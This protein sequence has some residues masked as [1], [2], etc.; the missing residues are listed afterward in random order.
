MGP[1]ERVIDALR[2]HGCRPRVRGDSVRAF[3]PA[4]DDRYP[5]L[6]ITAKPGRVLLHC[7]GGCRYVRVLDALGLKP[8]DL[9]VNARNT[10]PVRPKLTI[11]KVYQY[12]DLDD[13]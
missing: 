6:G 13:V 7:F 3:C 1:F 4:H 2:Q 8:R 10:L 11:E 5:S 12:R 9:F